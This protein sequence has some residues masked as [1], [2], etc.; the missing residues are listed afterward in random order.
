[1]EE[2]KAKYTCECIKCGHKIETDEHCKDLKCSEC[3]G[4]MRRAERPGPGQDSG[5]ETTPSKETPKEIKS[6]TT[7]AVDISEYTVEDLLIAFEGGVISKDEA[8]KRANEI[9][10]EAGIQIETEDKAGAVLNK[11]NKDNLKKSQELIQQVLDSSGAVV[12]E[13]EPKKV[14]KDPKPEPENTDKNE[15]PKD[16]K[17]LFVPVSEKEKEV[18][19]ETVISSEVAEVMSQKIADAVDK[20]IRKITGK[21]S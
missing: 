16:D 15:K 18:K 14:I 9:I 7:P 19:A 10:E 8:L 2:I 20:A 17:P 13:E 21:V 6:K 1:M 3:G 5:K 12:E 11:K 4:Q